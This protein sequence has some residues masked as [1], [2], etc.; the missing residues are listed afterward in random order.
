MSRDVTRDAGGSTVATK[1]H[2]DTK[3]QEA[4][5]E[6]SGDAP[7]DPLGWLPL[8]GGAKK[9][10]EWISVVVAIWL[11]L[12][13][14]GMIG[15]GFKMAAGDQAKELF[16]FAENP[17]VGLAVGILATAIMQS[18]STTTS[19][20]VGMIAGGLPLEVAVP[21][22]FG[23]NIGT[24]VTSTL[25]ALG[26]SGNKQQFHRA[27]SMATVHDFYNLLALA[28]FFPL[29]IFTGF[30]SKVSGVFA[31]SLAGEGDGVLAGIFEVIGDGV[32]AIT[33]PLV[34]LAK[35][36]VGPL[37]DVWGGIALSIGGVVLILVVIGY[38]GKML[39]ALLVGR[40][41][42]MLHAALGRGPITGILS[43]AIITTA[44][45]SSSTTT[46]LTV[47]LAASGKFK[48]KELFPFVVGANIG[49][50]VTGL[51]AAF[52]ASGVEAEA[53]MQG[54]L[55]HTMFNV[56]G[57]IVIMSLP[58]LRALPPKGANW[59]A[60]LADKNKW[61]VFIW[62]G[63]VFFALPLLAVLITNVFF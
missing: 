49:T 52:S 22:L 1:H 55:V 39:S 32:D 57:A 60:T 38:I 27:F 30:L 41:Q 2:P 28:I 6:N 3:P 35:F 48:V 46:S 58:F 9:A 13:A 7:A 56:F 17:F 37:G 11:L 18:S 59:L 10:A 21:M 14:V 50:T 47:P 8:S 43:G 26:L 4:Q 63:G 42:E 5:S 23:A 12:N 24:T 36:L 15:A 45:Q 62:V 33:E 40:A 53:A 16:S 29:E 61:Y 19:I 25:V 20:T 51:I 34:N 54:A 31:G 44:V